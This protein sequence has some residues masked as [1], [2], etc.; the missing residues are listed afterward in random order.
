[1]TKNI[2][3]LNLELF[4]KDKTKEVVV[5]QELHKM[6]KDNDTLEELCIKLHDQTNIVSVIDSCDEKRKIEHITII[7]TSDLSPEVKKHIKMYKRKHIFKTIRV[8]ITLPETR[9]ESK[10]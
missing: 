3:S 9:Q 10:R 5:V 8:Y 4:E 7:C 6:I 2:R 1:M